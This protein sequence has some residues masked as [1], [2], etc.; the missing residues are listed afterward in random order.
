MIS[1]Q[2]VV[3]LLRNVLV[4]YAGYVTLICCLS[5]LFCFSSSELVV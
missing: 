5:R 3:H 4:K 1:T 2:L